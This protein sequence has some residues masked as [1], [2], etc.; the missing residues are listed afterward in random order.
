MNSD[1][2]GNLREWENIPSQIAALAKDGKLNEHQGGLV[3][4]LRYKENW[5]LRELVLK[6]VRNLTIPS[7]ELIMEIL[8]IL[9]NEE[10]YWEMRLLAVD[11]IQD[12]LT[13]KDTVYEGDRCNVTR[14]ISERIQSLVNSAGPPILQDSLRN[15]LSAIQ[16][17]C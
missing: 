10:I 5:R 12:L 14:S 4:I 2:F 13:R 1:I 17:T 7:N 11:A 3:R 9:E 6:S 16:S 8:N 15:C